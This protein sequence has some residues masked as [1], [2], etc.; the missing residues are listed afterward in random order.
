MSLQGI[1]Y[2]GFLPCNYV[3]I[4]SVFSRGFIVKG[5]CIGHEIK[6]SYNDENFGLKAG[7]RR[8]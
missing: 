4:C 7:K 8:R 2:A 3:V 5:N 6:K 1:G